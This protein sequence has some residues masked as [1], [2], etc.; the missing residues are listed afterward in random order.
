MGEIHVHV[1]LFSMLRQKL[2]PASGG[3]AVLALPE[4]SSLAGLLEHLQIDI[5]VNCAVNGQ[6]ERDLT[7]RL[8]EGDQVQI[9]LP[10]GGGA[11]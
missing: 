3:K 4:G 10:I 9:F 6:V 5:L 7:H 1:T 2:P 8:Q 11:R